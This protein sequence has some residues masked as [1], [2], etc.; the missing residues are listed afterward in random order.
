MKGACRSAGRFLD[1]QYRPRAP[2]IQFHFLSRFRAMGRSTAND[3]GGPPSANRL[4]RSWHGPRPASEMTRSA[5][6]IGTT[7]RHQVSGCMIIGF[8]LM[9]K[10]ALLCKLNEVQLLGSSSHTLA[11][12]FNSFPALTNFSF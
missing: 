10:H 5:P 7:L 1:V 11:V 9:R 8:T 12:L 3:I 6:L 4:E 2:R